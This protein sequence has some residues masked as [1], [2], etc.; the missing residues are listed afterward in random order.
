MIASASSPS[1]AP[2][3]PEQQQ[4]GREALVELAVG[5]VHPAGQLDPGSAVSIQGGRCFGQRGALL[6][7]VGQQRALCRGTEQLDRVVQRRLLADHDPA[8]HEVGLQGEVGEVLE[9]VTLARTE[10][11][12]HE[13]AT[14]TWRPGR[15]VPDLVEERA[16]PVLDV[17]L[18]GPKGR[19]RRT[20][21]HPGT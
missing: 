9:Q 14:R 7:P 12:S 6:V 17:G 11:A 10:P 20:A 1:L 19:H 2:Q 4:C 21:R 18:G 16:E 5:R 15:P 3:P 8:D 13:Q